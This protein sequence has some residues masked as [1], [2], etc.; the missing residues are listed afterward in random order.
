MTSRATRADLVLFVYCLG[1]TTNN[2]RFAEHDVW[3]HVLISRHH[4]QTLYSCE[5]DSWCV[6]LFN[7]NVQEIHNQWSQPEKLDFGSQ[8][9][10]FPEIWTAKLLPREHSHVRFCY[11]RTWTWRTVYDITNYS[12]RVEC[13]LPYSAQWYN[14]TITI[15]GELKCHR[16]IRRHDKPSYSRLIGLTTGTT[17]C[18]PHPYL[19]NV[20]VCMSKLA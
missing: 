19:V 5:P 17:V 12:L 13:V 8:E 11:V 6:S 10:I 4:Q 9:R 15:T 1:H 20:N 16:F 14:Y 18:S 2:L 7:L 3:L